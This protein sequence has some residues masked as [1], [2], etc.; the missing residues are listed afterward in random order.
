MV[1]HWPDGR[2]KLLVTTCGMRLRRQ[3]GALMLHGSYTPLEVHGECADHVVAFA[4][5]DTSGTLLVIVPRLIAPLVTAGRP[6]P[7]GPESWAA[8]RIVLPPEMRADGYRHVMTGEWCASTGNGSSLPVA[9]ALDT[10]PVA[11]LW[12]PG[13]PSGV[14]TD[15]AEP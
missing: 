4:R 14:V 6:L 7:I 10:C 8:T 12:A 9:S 2:I 5:H 15:V 13:Q 3:H 11:L 1:T